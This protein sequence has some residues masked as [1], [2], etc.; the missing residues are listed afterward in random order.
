[1]IDRIA[2]SFV[3]VP[4][5]GGRTIPLIDVGITHLPE[6]KNCLQCSDGGMGGLTGEGYTLY[7]FQPIVANAICRQKRLKYV[8]IVVLVSENEIVSLD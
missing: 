1:M 8:N 4:C 5:D 2:A 6:Q 7:S 3:M